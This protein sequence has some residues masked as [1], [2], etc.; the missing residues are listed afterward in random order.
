LRCLYQQSHPGQFSYREAAAQVVDT[1]QRADSLKDEDDGLI[2]KERLVSRETAIGKIK[3]RAFCQPP[4]KLFPLA[5][6]DLCSYR[7]A[8]AHCRS[9][10]FPV[11]VSDSA[12]RRL[13]D[14]PN[15]VA[16]K[17]RPEMRDET[18]AHRSPGSDDWMND[19][20]EE[21]NVQDNR[22]GP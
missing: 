20:K 1:F 15:H 22:S 5:R 16:A 10:E 14:E 4:R 2:A 8:C 17:P 18:D 3:R 6:T 11:S 21:D 13:G 9:F 19:P 12:F 7:N